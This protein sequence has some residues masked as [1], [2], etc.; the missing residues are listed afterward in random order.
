MKKILTFLF[1]L[2]FPSLPIWMVGVCLSMSAPIPSF[3]L[4]SS[5]VEKVLLY[6][7]SRDYEKLDTFKEALKK[8]PIADSVKPEKKLLR[9]VSIYKLHYTDPELIQNSLRP[10]FPDVIFNCD[11]RTHSLL[12][13]AEPPV[14]K[15]INDT[16]IKLDAPPQQLRFEV[17]AVEINVTDFASYQSMFNDLTN[18]FK[19]S[20]DFQNQRLSGQ[21]TLEG[22][23]AGIIQKGQARLL[24]RPTITLIDRGKATVR[25][26]EKVPYA[27][28]TFI[29][30]TTP[31]TQI[32]FLD[33]GIELEITA[34]VNTHGKVTADLKAVV[35]SVK[36]WK[37]LQDKKVPLLSNREAQTRVI[38]ENKKT[39]VIGGLFEEESHE[40][41]STIPI[42]SDL[43]IIG[44][45]FTSPQKEK[46][47][48]D[49]LFLITPELL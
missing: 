14:A 46:T 28:T 45:L 3:A 10:L 11:L 1:Q 37:D 26:G 8:T 35:T 25:V 9:R 29:S 6:P 31:L 27:T 18:G 34:W 48:T 47:T 43:P 24:A 32:Q 19:L 49:I 4:P 21:P 2:H 17:K 5:G 36:T 39:L 33:T 41:I 12:F 30:Q 7:N 22:L 13:F 44:P 20:V 16:L 23:L 40:N 38:L 42:L 15:Q